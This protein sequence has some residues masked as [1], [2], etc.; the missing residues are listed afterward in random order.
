MTMSDT[1]EAL[2]DSLR[3]KAIAVLT[4][5]SDS[6]TGVGSSLVTPMQAVLVAAT[7]QREERISRI[8]SVPQWRSLENIR[9][10]AAG[11]SLILDVIG[12][13]A[14]FEIERLGSSGADLDNRAHPLVDVWARA[15]ATRA[16]LVEL[17]DQWPAGAPEERVRVFGD[18]VRCVCT[19]A[20]SRLCEMG[21]ESVELFQFI[22]P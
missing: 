4:P 15:E 21:L 19:E 5:S 1:L 13:C 11:A 18:S 17:F 2:R 8:G 9:D 22:R 6:S 20:A 14:E 3:S 10:G 16:L 12:L 7:E